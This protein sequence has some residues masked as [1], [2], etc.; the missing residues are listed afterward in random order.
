MS[1]R[2]DALARKRQALIAQAERERVQLAHA[3]Q[4]VKVA[5]RI[6]DRLVAMA[7][8][9]RAHPLLFGVAAAALALTGRARA[10][11]WVVKVLPAASIALR[12]GRSLVRR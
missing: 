7:R 6:V 11:R 8:Y 1:R 5:V 9:V 2:S 12:L 4:G 3:A 10:W